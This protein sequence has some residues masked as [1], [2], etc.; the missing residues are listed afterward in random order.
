MAENIKI[1][2]DTKLVKTLVAEAK[3]ERLDSAVRA[4]A[5]EAIKTLASDMSPQN[6]FQMAQVIAFSVNEL[7]R[8]AT[9]FMDLIAD[10][11]RVAVGDHAAFETK[12][13][14]VRAFIEAK[15]STTP[16]SRNGKKSIILD[17]V[18]ISARPS[19]PIYE[20]QAGRVDMGEMIADASREMT[21]GKIRYAM[22]VLNT[23]ATNFGTPFY[24]TGSGVI[25]ATIDPMV[26]HAMRWGGASL[27]G[28]IAVIQKLAALTGF[29]MTANQTQFSPDIINE[30]NRT[31]IIGSYK[32]AAVVQLVNPYEIDGV[33]PVL[34]TGKIYIVPNAGD[35][36][37]RPLKVVEEGDVFSLEAT[38]IDDKSYDVNLSQY[39]GAGI[40]YGATPFIGVYNDST[41]A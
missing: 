35:A 39:F 18:E 10:R 8:E 2:P 30:F 4:E 29:A 15:G 28:D 9:N 25:A 33:T 38:N 21:N 19:V 31:G 27:I 5:N 11:R 7:Q 22:N 13:P 20:I 26:Q 37:M 23:A 36:A 12:I 1:Y 24:G 16:R 17:T 32:G 3:G 14:G 6:R 41:L 40:A 34:S